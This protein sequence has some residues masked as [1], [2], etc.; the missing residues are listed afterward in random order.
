M[1]FLIPVLIFACLGLIA[2]VALTYA[3]KVFEVKVDER[4]EQISEVLP[5][6]NCGACG[7]AG[8]ADYADAIVNSGAETNLC[9]PGG[10]DTSSAI[11][12]ILGTKALEVEAQVAVVHCN[13]NCENTSLKYDF[14]GLASCKAAK[15]FYSGTGNCSYGCIGLGD[16]TK[17]CLAV[18]ISVVNGVAVVENSLCGGCGLCAEN[19][20]QNLISIKPVKSNVSVKCSSADNGKT[21]KLN[22]K[23]GCIGCKICEKKCPNDAIHVENFHAVIDYDKCTSCGICISACPVK[24]ISSCY[25][26]L[27]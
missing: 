11:A 2:G 9:K 1:D 12:S 17:V 19:C 16:C 22:C 14:D 13:G 25:P 10:N 26:E 4:I 5:Q 15:R 24:A 27:K 20:V 8:C 18:A 7:F 21:T 6:A 23:V 3:S